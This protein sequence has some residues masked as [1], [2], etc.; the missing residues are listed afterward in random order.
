M[1][2]ALITHPAC[3]AD[4]AGHWHPERPDRLRAVLRALKAE[5]FAPLLREAAPAATREQLLR[6]HSP[7]HV[8]AIL[9]I[10]PKAGELV[11]LDPDTAMGEAST[12]AALRA[13]GAAVMAV[14]AVMG[15]WARAA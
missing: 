9:S 12:E 8:D 15:G 13:A 6:V 10:R 3:L 14:D 7:A 5:E 4:D 11:Q 1:A 2:T